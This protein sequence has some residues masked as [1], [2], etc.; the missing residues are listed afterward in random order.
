MTNL[1]CGIDFGTSNSTC[2]VSTGGD[3]ELIPLENDSQT[4]PSTIFFP[5][6]SQPVFGREAV[7]AYINGEDGRLLKA[8]KSVLGTSLMQ[9]KTLINN[10]A[11]SFTDILALYFKNLKNTTE[12]H[13]GQDINSLVL[14]RPVHFHDNNEAADKKSQ[15]TLEDVAK[16]VGFKN[17]VFQFEPIAAAFSHEMRLQNEKLS[18]VVDLGGGTS[19]FTIIRLSPLNSQRSDRQQDILA[20]TGIR[21]GGTN[22][23]KSLSL[24]SFM[25]PL[26]LNSFYTDPFKKDKKLPLPSKVYHELS[27]WAKVP[28]A[29]TQKSLRDTKTILNTALEAEKVERLLEIQEKHLGHSLLQTVE[30]AKISLTGQSSTTA[31]FQEIDKPFEIELGRLDFEAVIDEHIQRISKAIG[32][33]LAQ[34]Q[35]KAED[36]K[37]IVLT[38]GSTEL[39]VI[40]ALINKT[41]PHAEISNDN[42]FGS[43]G[44]GLAQY[45]KNSKIF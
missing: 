15:D 4:L 9:E 20:T 19:D 35:V 14:G 5:D 27:D 31:S 36:I 24:N 18:L 42:K 38:G 17:I 34:A 28:F 6:D 1:F 26:G 22:F 23:D 2:A 39:P 11:V 37:L 43:V 41:F 21:V 29:Q 25:P 8:L 3:P 16:S 30:H 32:D 40:N 10:K 7:N 13:T 33:C 45:A 12:R 44:L